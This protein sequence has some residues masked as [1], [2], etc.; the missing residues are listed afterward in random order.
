MNIQ[1]AVFCLLLTTISYSVCDSDYQ[2]VYTVTCCRR[3]ESYSNECLQDIHLSLK[4][5]LPDGIPS[6]SV[7]QLTNGTCY[8]T[9]PLIFTGVSNITIRGQGYQYTHI[10][11]KHTNAG[12]VFSNSSHIELNDFTIDSC[13]VTSI[14]EETYLTGNASKSVVIATTKNVQ[15]QRLSITNSHG[16]GLFIINSFESVLLNNLT[17]ANNGLNEPELVYMHSRRRWSI[18]FV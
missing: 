6:N 5:I 18:Y 4:S 10:S 13:G 9:H 12:L 15:L 1:T 7:L 14:I 3:D 16:Y 17:F 11:C 8:L 2:N